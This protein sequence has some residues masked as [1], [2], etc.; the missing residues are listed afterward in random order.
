VAA[1]VRFRSQGQH[2]SGIS[3]R[4]ST[5]SAL[6]RWRRRANDAALLRLARPDERPD[7]DQPGCDPIPQ[8][9]RVLGRVTSFASTM[10][11]PV[12]G[13]KASCPGRS[14][15][16]AALGPIQRTRQGRLRSKGERGCFSTGELFRH[17][18]R[19]APAANP[20]RRAGANSSRLSNS[21]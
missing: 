17:P 13:E 7:R 20:S 16:P 11:S 1:E 19:R 12:I 18:S 5:T 10:V 8:A 4:F 2:Y 9:K 6:K 21:T 3:V 15:Q 14:S